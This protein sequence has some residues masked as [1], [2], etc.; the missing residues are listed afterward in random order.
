MPA[1]PAVPALR[2]R[3]LAAPR[4]PLRRL[5]STAGQAPARPPL[6][7]RVDVAPGRAVEAVARAAPVGRSA[8]SLP[9]GSA[10]GA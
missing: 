8:E 6:R 10:L 7:P 9:R 4:V 1:R 3:R 5:M 2:E